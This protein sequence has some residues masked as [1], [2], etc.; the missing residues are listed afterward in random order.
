MG[1]NCHVE[2]PLV[3]NTCGWIKGVGADVLNFIYYNIDCSH[4]VFVAV[5]RA[6]DVAARAGEA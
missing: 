2:H 6:F 1:R 3:I 5:L 4:V